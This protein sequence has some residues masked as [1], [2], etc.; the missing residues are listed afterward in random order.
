[1]AQSNKEG[2]VLGLT[3]LITMGLAAGGYFLFTRTDSPL[4]LQTDVADVANSSVIAIDGSVT[5]AGIIRELRTAYRLQNP[6]VPVTYG[7]PDGRPGGSNKGMQNLMAG[8]INLA[9]TSRGLS[10]EEAQAGIQ[11][12]MIAKDALAIA[13]GLDN[14]F[15]GSLTEDQVRGIFT[16]KITNWSQVGGPN[17]PIK[18]INRAKD[19]GTRDVF[20][21]V[22]LKD[23]DF[24]PDGPNFITL[25]RDETT[26]MLRALGKNGIG[27]STLAQIQ[28][29]RTV[30]ILKINGISPADTAK[31]KSG[32]YPLSRGLYLALPKQTSPVVKEFVDFA[33]SPAGQ[34]AIKRAG[35]IP[36]R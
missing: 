33:L 36:V 16:G 4:G 8:R 19:S 30:R 2:I 21:E 10:P 14:P 13:V 17:L 11:L 3:L 20:R 28:G 15:Q 24:A 9:A 12:V 23:E 1:M 26:P 35:Y 6:N 5:M 25:E 27:Y 34:M 31:V 7:I 32:E 22:A 29:Q 18:V